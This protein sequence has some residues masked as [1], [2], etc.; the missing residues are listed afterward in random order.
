MDIIEVPSK[1]TDY[2][3]TLLVRG[4]VKID[5]RMCFTATKSRRPNSRERKKVK[6]VTLIK[7][8]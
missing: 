6:Y 8:K 7:H 3:N 1:L 4:Y 5:E 2:I